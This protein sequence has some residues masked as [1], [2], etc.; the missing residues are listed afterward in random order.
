MGVSDMQKIFYSELL[1]LRHLGTTKFLIIIPFLTVLIAFLMGGLQIFVPFSVYWWE[2][3][4]LYL[5]NGLLFIVDRRLEDQAGHFQ[6]VTNRDFTWKIS[7]IKM[8]LIGMRTLIASLFLL[9]FLSLV[10]FIYTGFIPINIP[11]TAISLIL[12]WMTTLWNIPLLYLMSKYMSQ[13]ILLA[14]NTLVCLLIAPFIAQSPLW[15]VF[16]YTYHYKIAQFLLN[17]KPSG[18]IIVN[19]NH[20]SILQVILT[21]MLSI[22]VTLLLSFSLQRR[23][24]NAKE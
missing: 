7:L 14:L 17:L 16:P 8:V 20:T 3:I 13:F 10:A 23:Q 24:L 5:V 2:A 18:D 1:K 21:M 12:I 4:F 15:F 19:T 22:V 9:A 6:N 11:K